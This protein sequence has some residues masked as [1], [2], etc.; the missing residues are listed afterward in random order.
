MREEEDF[1]KLYQTFYPKVYQTALSVTHDPFLAE[2]VTQETFLKIYYHFNQLSDVKHVNAWI[3]VV[4]TRTAIDVLRKEK[5]SP[6]LKVDESLFYEENLCHSIEA[7]VEA[8]LL[9]EQIEQQLKSLK[10]EY[11]QVIELRYYKGFK[12]K[13]IESAL[14]ITKSAVKTRLHRARQTLKAKVAL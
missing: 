11:R 5:K 9:Q 7:E 10:P 12:E 1:H 8:H 4:T 13:E 6:H 2:D 3:R 14:N